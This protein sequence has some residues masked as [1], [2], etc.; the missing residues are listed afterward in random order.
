MPKRGEMIPVPIYD[1]E[2]KQTKLWM[3]PA[4]I[5]KV[6]VEARQEHMVPVD[7]RMRI[8]VRVVK[9]PMGFKTYEVDAILTRKQ[10]LRKWA[11][12]A[13]RWICLKSVI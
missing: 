2:D 3:M 11:H 9:D 6:I 1:Y 8:N 4:Y 12:I 7:E 5:R 13:W 10:R